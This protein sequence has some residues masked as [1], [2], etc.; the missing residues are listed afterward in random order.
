MV[1]K[2]NRITSG[3]DALMYYNDKLE[4]MA[5]IMLSKYSKQHEK[6]K[7]DSYRKMKADWRNIGIVEER[8]FSAEN[9]VNN[10]EYTNKH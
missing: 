7:S 6:C 10:H 5:T 2:D 1:W 3:F 9:I 8:E 4:D